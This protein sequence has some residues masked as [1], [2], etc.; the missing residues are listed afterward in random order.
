MVRDAGWLLLALALFSTS[1]K[2][3]SQ[4]FCEETAMKPQISL[5]P[6]VLLTG[7]WPVAT[8]PSAHGTWTG[9]ATPLAMYDTQRQ[10]YQV[11]AIR[12]TSG[13]KMAASGLPDYQPPT[14]PLAVLTDSSAR[15]LALELRE[16]ARIR[17]SG[18]MG[19]G[20]ILAPD[21]GNLRADSTEHIYGICVR[22]QPEVLSSAP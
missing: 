16:G 14:N 12:V 5:W 13:P 7:C 6:L 15:P 18:T 19:S 22:G 3:Y 21:G 10:V 11:T 20:S 8:T 2:M 1:L 17:I 4:A 9:T